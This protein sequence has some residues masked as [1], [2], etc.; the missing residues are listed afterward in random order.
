M[1]VK[2]KQNHD[3]KPEAKPPKEPVPVRVQA[4]HRDY[5]IYGYGRHKYGDQDYLPHKPT[6]P[7]QHLATIEV[8]G[9]DLGK[10]V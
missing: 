5:G 4:L 6:P 3:I 9:Q 8:F 7:T 10:F 1:H 2:Y